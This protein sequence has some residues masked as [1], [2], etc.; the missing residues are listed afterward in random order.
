MIGTS[1]PPFAAPCHCWDRPRG[2][3]R[4]RPEPQ[5]FCLFGEAFP[6]AL[7]AFRSR[8]GPLAWSFLSWEKK[9]RSNPLRILGAA[10]LCGNQ[11][12]DWRDYES[13][14]KD[15]SWHKI[16]PLCGTTGSARWGLPKLTGAAAFCF[17]PQPLHNILEAM[18]SLE[19]KPQCRNR[20]HDPRPDNHLLRPA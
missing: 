15:H 16:K 8:P 3:E 18:P 10:Y 17:S 11:V 13:H 9:L 12:T 2:R 1:R 4:T 14:R 5:R 6:P 19:L 20:N 7:S